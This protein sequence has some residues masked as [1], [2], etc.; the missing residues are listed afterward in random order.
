[1]K[2]GNIELT[3]DKTAQNMGRILSFKQAGDLI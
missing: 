2:T 3:L 1:M